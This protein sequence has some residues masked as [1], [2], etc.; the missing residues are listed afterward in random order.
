MRSRRSIFATRL[1]RLRLARPTL[2][3]NERSLAALENAPPIPVIARIGDRPR[4]HIADGQRSGRADFGR[5]L[6]QARAREACSNTAASGVSRAPLDARKVYSLLIDR[7]MNKQSHAWKRR[8]L[9]ALLVSLR[10]ILAYL[11]R[12]RAT[13]GQP[14]MDE[15]S[16]SAPALLLDNV[17]KTFVRSARSMA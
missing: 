6:R 4:P 12:E 17:V 15:Q 1:E 8:P 14:Y 10:P 13:V 16:Q 5:A 11:L 3:A 9:I 7:A 2:G